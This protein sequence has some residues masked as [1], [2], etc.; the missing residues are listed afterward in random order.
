MSRFIHFGISIVL[1]II[2]AASCTDKP[3]GLE[4]M[5]IADK[6]QQVILVLVAD[7]TATSG[8]L[9]YFDR[10]GN[11]W[12]PKTEPFK[13]SVGRNGTAW[14]QGLHKIPTGAQVKKEG[15]GKAPTGIFELGT[16]F[17]Y[18]EHV[19]FSY[20][21]RQSTDRDYYVDDVTSGD[22]NSWVTI[23]TSEINDPKAFWKSVERMKRPDHLYELG[24]EVKHNKE[25]A[26]SDMGSAIFLH[27]W[28][29]E[30]VSTAGCTAMPKAQIQQMLEWLDAAKNPLLIQ[31]REDD[32]E[33]L[34]FKN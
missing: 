13:V 15:D 34:E 6:Y 14:G 7:D 2:L 19:G 20:P 33:N 9:Q 8:K 17:G 23:D 11:H 31:V 27:V 21:Y 28:K 5:N 24:L 26:V 1:G 12:N 10:V 25:P 30:N 29:A 22:Y 32:L 4:A 3:S 18:Q 16:A